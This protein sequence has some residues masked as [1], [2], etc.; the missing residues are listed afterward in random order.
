[1]KSKAKAWEGVEKMSLAKMERRRQLAKLSFEEKI[2]ILLHLQSIARGISM[3]SGRKRHQV[4]RC[5]E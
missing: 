1:M 2:R 4:W 5:G 3:A